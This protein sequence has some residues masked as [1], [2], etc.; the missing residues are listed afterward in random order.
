MR[1]LVLE[2]YGAIRDEGRVADRTLD[3]L[4]RREKRLYANERRAVAEAVYGLL[5][6]EGRL[7]YLL[8]ES[9]GDELR[10]L[11]SAAKRALFYEA[12][13]VQE[14]RIPPARALAEGG[15]SAALLPGLV[16]CAAPGELLSRLS[17]DPAKRL[18]VAESLPPWMAELFLRELDEEGAF[19]LARS[20]NER[21]PLTIRMNGLRTDRETLIARLAS[22]GVEAKAT[23]WSPDGLHVDGRQNLFRLRSFEEGLFEIQDEG[24]QV[25]ARLLDPHPGW[26]VVDSCAGA[27]GKTLALAASMKNRG[28]L[29]ALD[30]DERRLG[31][32]GPRA[33]RAGV[34][35]WESHVVPADGLPTPL[36]EKLGDRADAVLID[37][38]CT[39]LGVLRR[40]P[41]ARFRLDEG[42]VQRFAGIQKELLARYAAL[43]KPGGRIVYATCSIATEENEGVVETVLAEHPELELM[44]P[45]TTLGEE[46]A[47]R[48]G[49]RRYLKL[50]PHVHGTDGFFAA[51]LR[52]RA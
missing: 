51:L 25:L 9:L 37:A 29:V 30:T 26:L 31:M 20:M 42:S 10:A 12:L 46:L 4:L 21:A 18:A 45:A 8:E 40:N 49:A 2:A 48:L 23:S 14:R 1:A 27:G 22:E 7:T 28:R 52:R 33:R 50:L 5:R 6:A 44:P 13:R 15:L 3:Y 47:E 35:N 19:A 17:E 41:D 34:H 39:G 24:S 36:A 38:P 32:L 11:S 16:A 43:A